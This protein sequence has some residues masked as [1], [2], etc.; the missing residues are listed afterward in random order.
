MGH[1]RK[2]P[3]AMNHTQADFLKSICDSVQYSDSLP[4]ADYVIDERK[5]LRFAIFTQW[6]VEQ[7]EI[8]GCLH[9]ALGHRGKTGHCKLT[10]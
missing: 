2:S 7:F 8:L 4:G 1:P 5:S 9:K 3:N 10:T 6:K